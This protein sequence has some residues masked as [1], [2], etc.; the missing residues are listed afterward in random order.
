MKQDQG[1]VGDKALSGW[2]IKL[3]DGLAPFKVFLL[4]FIVWWLLV[5]V[6]PFVNSGL[7][8]PSPISTFLLCSTFIYTRLNIYSAGPR[9][10][11]KIELIICGI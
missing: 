3:T 9:N 11:I 6:L 4:L 7:K 1:K 5:W 10:K 8:T 2:G